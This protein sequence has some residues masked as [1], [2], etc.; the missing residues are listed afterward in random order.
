MVYK[1]KHPARST[2]VGGEYSEAQSEWIRAGL[3]WRQAHGGR[4]PT[5][6]EILAIAKSLGYRRVEPLTSP[7]TLKG[8]EL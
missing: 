5:S 6:R 7:D 4:L 2:N 1:R 3:A 8:T